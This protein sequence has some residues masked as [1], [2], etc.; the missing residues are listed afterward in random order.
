MAAGQI[1]FDDVLTSLCLAAEAA[2]YARTRKPKPLGDG[3]AMMPVKD[4][5]VLIDFD[6]D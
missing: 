2:R 5:A 1:H 6:G 4:V 3:D